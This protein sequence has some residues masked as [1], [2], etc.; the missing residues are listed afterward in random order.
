[1]TVRVLM[2]AAAFVAVFLA[3]IMFGERRIHCKERATLHRFREPYN[4]FREELEPGKHRPAI[5]YHAR[6]ERKWEWA[7]LFT[8]RPIEPD[9]PGPEP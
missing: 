9:P 5:E 3:G 1:M 2:L 4:R 7:A 8:V 6:M